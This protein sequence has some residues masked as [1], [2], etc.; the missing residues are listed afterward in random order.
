VLFLLAFT[1]R[2]NNW[3]IVHAV[4]SFVIILLLV[5]ALAMTAIPTVPQ[6]VQKSLSS[7]R[8]MMRLP[9]EELGKSALDIDIIRLSRGLSPNQ[10][11]ALINRFLEMAGDQSP[12]RSIVEK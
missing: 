4:K 10:P 9:A 1:A 3:R 11:S 7:L 6:A 2:F 5:V 12:G 8:I